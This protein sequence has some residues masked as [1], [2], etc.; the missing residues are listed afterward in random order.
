MQS[1]ASISD[2]AYRHFLYTGGILAAIPGG[3]LILGEGWW[4]FAFVLVPVA[5]GTSFYAA[6]LSRH[7]LSD[8]RL[9]LLSVLTYTFLA[10]ILL[11]WVAGVVGLASIGY[12]AFWIVSIALGVSSLGYGVGWLV[13]R[14][15]L[16]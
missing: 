14:P 2:L 7:L 11:D 3:V 4:Y 6:W 12:W 16:R 9:K 10:A 13:R 8:R 15:A 1:T 5:A